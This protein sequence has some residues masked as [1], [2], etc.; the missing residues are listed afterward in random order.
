M[1]KASG[2]A[3]AVGE[4]ASKKISSRRNALTITWLSSFAFFYTEP[5]LLQGV[6]MR[7]MMDK[8]RVSRVKFAYMLDSMGCSVASISPINDYAPFMVGLISAQFA[9]LGIGDSPWGAYFGMIPF[10]LYGMFAMIACLFVIRTGLDI[11]P[12]YKAEMRAIKTGKLM[13]D[14]DVPIVADEKIEIEDSKI[15]LLN[16]IA[17]MVGLLGTIFLVVFW[18]GD[19]ATNGFRGS[20]LNG[21]MLLAMMLGYLVASIVA[22]AVGIGKKIFNFREAIDHWVGGVKNIMIVPIIVVLAWSIGSVAGDMNIRGYLVGLVE[23]S[24]SPGL[25]PAIIFAIGA[26]IAFSTGSSWGTWTIMMPIA[27]PM[28]HTLGVS[29]TLTIGAVISGG[30]FGDHCSP[31]SDTTIMSSTGAA[32]DH[33]EHVKTQLPYALITAV[34]AFIGFI[35]G[36]LSGVPLLSIPVAAVI[37]AGT[38]YVLHKRSEKIEDVHFPTEA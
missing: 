14:D 38:L 22:A 20:F 31:I 23:G 28:A 17:P 30:L 34:A 29:M 37:I 11:G 27:I 19:I 24:L 4:F 8:F 6:I 7:P 15:S 12:M 1:M 3:Y 10:N 32:C 13:G 25:V 33:I 35:V 2:A 9:I 16:F 36:G 21:D 18:T 26:I 5:C